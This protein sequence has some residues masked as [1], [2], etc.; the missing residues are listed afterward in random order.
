MR[1][2][3]VFPA[4]T[5]I[6]TGTRSRDVSATRGRRPFMRRP[7]CRPTVEARHGRTGA[8]V[9]QRRLSRHASLGEAQL[10][11][12]FVA[13]PTTPP[14][15]VQP[16]VED[17]TLHLAPQSTSVVHTIAG[18]SVQVPVVR[19]QVSVGIRHVTNPGLPQVEPAEQRVI[20]P[21]QFVGTSPCWDNRFTTCARLLT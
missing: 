19:S 10:A 1:T 17:L 2:K 13:V 4:S 15:D 20:L 11:Q 12:Q 6:D 14:R 5:K 21:L 18:S 16:S 7:A 8:T 9:Y 3:E